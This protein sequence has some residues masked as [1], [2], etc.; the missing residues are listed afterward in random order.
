MADFSVASI[1]ES[2]GALNAESATNKGVINETYEDIKNIKAQEVEQLK[3]AQKDAELV[4]RTEGLGELERQARNDKAL[5]QINYEEIMSS[6]APKLLEQFNTIKQQDEAITAKESVGFFD[7]PFEW[8]Y[9]QKTLDKDL[10]VRNQTADSLNQNVSLIKAAND[11]A[12][13]AAATSL[14]TRKLVTEASVEASAR[15]AGTEFMLKA[16]DAKIQA[17]T[18][19]LNRLQALQGL[20][21]RGL[22]ALMKGRQVILGEEDRAMRIQEFNASQA[23]RRIRLQ[24]FQKTKAAEGKEAEAEMQLVQIYNLGAKSVGQ[25][26]L[27]SVD[28]F[29]LMTRTASSKAKAE[30]LID[31][32]YQLTSTGSLKLGATPAAS[33]DVLMATNGRLAPT[34]RKLEDLIVSSSIAVKS[35][36]VNKGVDLKNPTAV[37]DSVNRFISDRVI[38][39]AS[40]VSKNKE[41]NIYAPPTV[42]SIVSAIPAVANDPFFK[43]VLA[44]ELA[45]IGTKEL[46]PQEL[47]TRATAAVLS[48]QVSYTD[49]LKGIK[50]LAVAAREVNNAENNYEAV[51]IPAQTGF[52]AKIKTVPSNRFFTADVSLEFTNDAALAVTFN[53]ML[54][55]ERQRSILDG[56]GNSNAKLPAGV[57]SNLI[58]PSGNLPSLPA[59][60]QQPRSAA[61]QSYLNESA[62]ADA[63]RARFF[64][65]N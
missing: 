58:N 9:N 34:Q 50:K 32:G 33:A 2:I 20:N 1:L 45:V 11:L 53:R 40:D 37:R 10:A 3:S 7:N 38:A 31:L 63:E 57:G 15:L 49:A 8:I 56:G 43:A 4:K 5:S 24:E 41:S 22:D 27:Q 54:V 14:A 48:K 21:E 26:P 64:G 62:R 59:L 65:G 17:G 61:T 36:Q 18:L 28:D 25:R 55:Q 42:N 39:D 46:N 44:P 6:L 35:G 23:E 29:K 16:N 19:N 47:M 52:K 13:E 30:M 12:Q 60:N 51:G